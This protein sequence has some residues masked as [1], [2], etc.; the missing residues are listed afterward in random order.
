[1][2]TR[3][4][5][6]TLL[7]VL[8]AAALSTSQDRR[9]GDFETLEGTW[10]F[11]LDAPPTPPAQILTT[12]ARGGTIIGDGNNAQPSLRSS[13]HGVWTRRSYLEF[14]STWRRWNFDAAGIFTGSNE[15]RMDIAVDRGLEAFSG[16]V[17]IL[18]LDRA[19]TVTA[20][21]PGTFRAARVNVRR[22]G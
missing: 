6:L 4:I 8:A 7:F 20:S 5:V 19:G 18:T 11:D 21:R 14:T 10:I 22:P 15:F 2:I 12:F 17:E 3:R 9:S 1:M 16:T 13:W